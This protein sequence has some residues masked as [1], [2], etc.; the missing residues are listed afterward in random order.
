MRATLFVQMMLEPGGLSVWIRQ[1]A[2][3]SATRGAVV[4]MTELADRVP[5]PAGRRQLRF[6]PAPVRMGLVAMLK[7]A[8]QRSRAGARRRPGVSRQGAP[9]PTQ[10]SGRIAV[11]PKPLCRAFG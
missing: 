8:A 3:T 5:G 11:L 2:P 10:A 9:E 7:G 4:R 1:A 6:A